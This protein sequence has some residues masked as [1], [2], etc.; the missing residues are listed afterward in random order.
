MVECKSGARG[1]AV[2]YYGISIRERLKSAGAKS[3][4]V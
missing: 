2:F 4:A 1:I 3:V